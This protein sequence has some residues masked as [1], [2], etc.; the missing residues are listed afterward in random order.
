MLN[1]D[2]ILQGNIAI[3]EFMGYWKNNE[4][5]VIIMTHR[6]RAN[7]LPSELKYHTDWNLL[8]EVVEKIQDIPF[9]TRQFFEI[10]N[11]AFIDNDILRVFNIVSNKCKFIVAQHSI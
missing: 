8:M 10:E 3:A 1:K 4:F 2:E 6:T 7:T 9:N 11:Q 5:G